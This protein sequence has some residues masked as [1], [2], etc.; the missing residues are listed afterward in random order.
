[1]NILDRLRRREPR[2]QKST[3]QLPSAVEESKPRIDPTTG[4][5]LL[6]PDGDPNTAGTSNSPSGRLPGARTVVAGE[7]TIPSVN[8]ERSMHA[9]VRNGVAIGTVALLGGGFLVWYYAAQIAQA[10]DA[11]TEAQRAAD[12]RAGGESKL[13]PL[14]RVD[15]PQPVLAT[16]AA[17]APTASSEDLLGPAPPLPPDSVPVASR[18]NHPPVKTA[19]QLALERMLSEPVLLHTSLASHTGAAH[20]PIGTPVPSRPPAAPGMM[21]ATAGQSNGHAPTG[22]SDLT[23]RL[24]PTYTPAVSAQLLPTRRFLLPKGAFVDC[25]LETAIDSSLDGLVTCIG[26]SDVYSADGKVVLLER[27]TKYVGEK[28]GDVRHGQSRVFVLWSEARTP[29]G[30]VVKL[31]SPGTDELGRAG[32][33]GFVD[34]HFWDRFGAAILISVIDGGLQALAASQQRG[35]TETAVVL[36]TQG[37]RDVLTEVL[38]GT[39]AIP[40]TLVKNQGDRVQVLVARDLD[41]R[42]VYALRADSDDE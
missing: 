33:P 38:K 7:R 40:P 28:R 5:I 3:D 15:P 42:S 27:G 35:D 39:I 10:R 17:P 4:E 32:L 26:A 29:T 22:G 23:S 18:A 12:V 19:Q 24:Q 8:R 20:Q 13:P 11:G 30:V 37:T 1:M 21:G 31:A 25:T 9:L 16:A 41:F 2:P 14:G 36:G 34:T 6:E